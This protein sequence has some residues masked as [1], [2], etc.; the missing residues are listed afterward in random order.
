MPAPHGSPTLQSFPAVSAD[1]PATLRSRAA[2]YHA[3]SRDVA[4]LISN[5]HDRQVR[6]TLKQLA[7]ELHATG[8]G[9]DRQARAS[10]PPGRFDAALAAAFDADE[11]SASVRLGIDLEGSR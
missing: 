2:Q 7:I 9:C 5:A 8:D 11:R 10:Q 1:P 6:A 4:R 3:A